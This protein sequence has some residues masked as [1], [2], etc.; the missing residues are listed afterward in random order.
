[1][2]QPRSTS[3]RTHGEWRSSRRLSSGVSS[4]VSSG[5]AVAVATSALRRGREAIVEIDGHLDQVLDWLADPSQP[6]DRDL[7]DRLAGSARRA[8][9]ALGALSASGVLGGP[10][11][12]DIYLSS[13]L[14][15]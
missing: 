12:S 3:P 14:S 15:N 1:M 13:E 5:S 6:P 2:G 7:P 8:G 11:G 9:E 4:G 10:P